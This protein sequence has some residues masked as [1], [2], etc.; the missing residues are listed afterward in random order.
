MGDIAGRQ[1]WALQNV[2]DLLQHLRSAVQNSYRMR[3]RIFFTP[4]LDL[5]YHLSVPGEGWMGY[6][7]LILTF[8]VR[9]L[10]INGFYSFELLTILLP[11]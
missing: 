8:S 3:L 9:L 4:Y 6:Q 5:C 11:V 10:A 2:A 1:I 7:L